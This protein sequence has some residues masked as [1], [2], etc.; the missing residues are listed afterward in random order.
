MPPNNVGDG[1]TSEDVARSNGAKLLRATVREVPER[2]RDASG[3]F[4]VSADDPSFLI[5]HGERDPGVP[6]SQ[7]RR[8]HDAL[9]AVEVPS[10][11]FVVPG[12]GHGGKEFDRPEVRQRVVQF[13][14]KSLMI[15]S[16]EK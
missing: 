1:R 5:V 2:A 6:L 14:R 12:A 8:L 7:S 13:F 16:T 11:L 4:H 10:N 15:Q 9:R 3:L